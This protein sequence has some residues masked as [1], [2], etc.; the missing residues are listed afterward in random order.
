MKKLTIMMIFLLFP[1]IFCGTSIAVDYPKEP[2]TYQVPF[3]PGGQTDLEARRQQPFLEKDLGVKIMVQYKP[4]GGGSVGWATMLREKNDGYF[5]SGINVPHIILQPL[6][7]GNSGYKTEQ[8]LPVAF[9]Q[10]T[11]IGIAV[12]KESPIKS[13]KDLVESA[14]ATP[15]GVLC[16]GSGTWSGHH[17]AFL[18]LQQLAD[19][20]MTY[21][22]SKGAAESVAQFLGGHVKVLFGN[23]NDLFQHR[24]KIRV[25]AFGTDKPFEPMPE[26]PTFKDSGYNLLASIDRGI[27]VPP[28]TPPEII[29]RL[30]KAFIKISQNPAVIKQM[31]GTGFVPMSMGSEEAKSYIQSKVVEWTPVVKRFKK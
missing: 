9:F 1:M 17:I 11:P 24:D 15:G 26:V 30:E 28:N 20:Q 16:G 13:V 25:L 3:G 27:A 12:L 22:P 18:Q 2:I 19:I 31:L 7:R 14:K 29:D 8:I 21:I 6:A 4:G 23:S 10:T 5:I